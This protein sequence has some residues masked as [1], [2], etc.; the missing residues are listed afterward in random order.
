M[1][2]T[3]C[4]E[5]ITP[6]SKAQLLDSLA[7]LNIRID[8]IQKT[9][10]SGGGEM[11]Y[12]QQPGKNHRLLKSQMK[13]DVKLYLLQSIEGRTDLI[14][15]KP[16]LGGQFRFNRISLLGDRWAIASFEDGHIGG[17]MLLSYSIQG[18]K[19]IWKSLDWYSND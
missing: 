10:F 17:L 4:R 9:N 3:S 2:C 18:S 15:M 16:V 7:L 6:V 19:V 1:L 14:P 13:S 11:D 8:S 5:E 12:W